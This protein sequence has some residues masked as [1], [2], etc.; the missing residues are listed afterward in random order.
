MRPHLH[1]LAFLGGLAAVACGLLGLSAAATAQPA[2]SGPLFRI[3]PDVPRYYTDVAVAAGPD[4][5]FTVAWA[6]AWTDEENND[7]YLVRAQRFAAAGGRL[8]PT[9]SLAEPLIWGEV[10][11][12][13]G[14]AGEA[15]VVWVD[16]RRLRGRRLDARGRP[17]GATMLLD[18]DAD[19]HYPVVVAHPAGGFLVAWERGAHPMARRVLAHGILGPKVPLPSSL[20][21]VDLT[22]SRR[23]DVALVGDAAQAPGNLRVLLQVLDPSLQPRGPALR[24]PIPAPWRNG[25]QDLSVEFGTGDEL[26]VVWQALSPAE[27][28]GVLA[29][30]YNLESGW[31]GPA[32]QIETQ[33]EGAGP[34]IAADR[35]GGFLVVWQGRY[36]R[37]LL[38]RRIEPSGRLG[39]VFPLDPD[40]LG[41]RSG[42]RLGVAAQKGGSFVVTWAG[43]YG[44]LGQ[45]FASASPGQIAL[46]RPELVALEGEGRAQLEIVRREGSRGEIRASWSALGLDATPGED[47]DET[48][49]TVTFADGDSLPKRIV[50]P[51]WDDD[52]PE[53]DESF[54]IALH[55][56][57]GGVALGPPAAA[58]V[59]IRDDD[60]PSPLL[61]GAGPP[62]QIRELELPSKDWPPVCCLDL[63]ALS[64][65]GF[66][67]AWQL[68][69]LGGRVEYAVL[70]AAGQ[71]ARTGP[72]SGPPDQRAPR[73]LSR[74][75][76][77]FVLIWKVAYPYIWPE[78]RGWFAQS[79]DAQGEPLRQQVALES[80]RSPDDPLR[81]AP[82][83]GGGFAALGR[84]RVGSRLDLFIER[85]G[86][87]GHRLGE[88][89]QVNEQP[90]LD[91]WDLLLGY[92][93]LRSS[94]LQLDIAAS[95]SGAFVVVW[96]RLPLSGRPGGIFARRVSASGVPLG[97]EIA[98]GGAAGVV[99][100]LDVAAT[101]DGGFAV[102][103]ES[104][105]DGD[106]WGISAR[107]LDAS[108]API[109]D[110]IQ[111]NSLAAGLQTHPQASFDPNGDLLVVWRS[112]GELRGQLF[113][114]PGQREGSEFAVD[115]ERGGF[116]TDPALVSTGPGEWRVLW[117]WIAG[118][119]THGG[120]YTRRLRGGNL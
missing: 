94:E 77:G 13:V 114:S 15:L 25:L 37:D 92:L 34:A 50:I 16:A 32:R 99:R 42:G 88:P 90:V 26:V 106:G 6:E 12:A 46:R 57:E 10:D 108:G 69:S 59:E 120:V 97:N 82:A 4:G 104:S 40:G 93:E 118:D 30:R 68:G 63:A 38:G 109:G 91:P 116:Q 44:I 18:R 74:P 76:G 110:E 7:S 5:G 62:L 31:V 22:V 67:A 49:G 11:V 35:N 64:T 66:A 33:E 81:A 87:D 72:A 70:D 28:T 61:A 36:T 98:V 103:W 20:R 9:V 1:P 56:P 48:S 3:D 73:L 115:P 117:T 95:P 85:Y 113:A 8:G 78:A 75:D 53:G 96:V 79:F 102:A 83:P 41:A 17:L 107:W 14:G 29:R 24:I 119:L 86:A 60:A 89:V 84:R 71:P 65:G 47:F 105:G 101:P 112:G 51:L 43:R 55:D 100:R 45:R 2:P 54:R 58:R 111:V 23:G 19:I 80:F 52:R 27:R 21:L 39:P